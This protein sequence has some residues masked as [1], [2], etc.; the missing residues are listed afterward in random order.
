MVVYTVVVQEP[1]TAW[2]SG[3]RDEAFHLPWF[4]VQVNNARSYID[5]NTLNGG[6][7]IHSYCRTM[8]LSVHRRTG[9]RHG[10]LGCQMFKLPK[11]LQSPHSCGA[12]PLEVPNNDY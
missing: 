1:G 4:T 11:D 2:K 9:G 3:T 5:L 10:T 7:A 12:I 8:S 6:K